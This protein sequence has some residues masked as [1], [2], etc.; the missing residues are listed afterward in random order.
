[1]INLL[2]KLRSKCEMQSHPRPTDIKVSY[3][4]DF[5]VATKAESRLSSD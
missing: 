5:E 1:M 2:L 4:I 3:I